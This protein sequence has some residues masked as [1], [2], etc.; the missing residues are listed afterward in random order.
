[1]A[2][3]THK[4]PKFAQKYF[5]GNASHIWGTETGMNIAFPKETLPEVGF[6][7]RSNVGK[8]S[9]IN[10][11]MR[12]NK[13]ARTSSTP[14][15]TKAVHF[16]EVPESFRLVDLPGYGFAKLSKQK[17]AEL[18]ELIW[19]YFSER[20]NLQCIYVLIDGRHGLKNVDKQMLEEFAELGVTTKI[21]LT[22]ADKVRAGSGMRKRID[23]EVKEQ[24][25]AFPY[26]SDDVLWVSSTNG[27]GVDDA[28]MHVLNQCKIEK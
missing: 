2:F 23:A 6:I 28:R 22:K 16:Y 7:G 27:E 14:G 21:I 13:L 1:M 20:R 4:L 12:R 11:V 5:N 10:A 19:G 9:L 26:V 3:E 25:Q 24:L 18:A 17:S 8:S 15:A